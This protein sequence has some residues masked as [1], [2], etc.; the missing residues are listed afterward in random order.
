MKDFQ[1]SGVLM[2]LE[3]DV[4]EEVPSVDVPLAVTKTRR[5]IHDLARHPL[6][7]VELVLLEQDGAADESG[8][9]KGCTLARQLAVLRFGV[10]DGG[11]RGRETP[12]QAQCVGLLLQGVATQCMDGVPRITPIGKGVADHGGCI[13]QFERVLRIP[14]T[15][16]IRP[17]AKQA[18]HSPGLILGLAGDVVPDEARGGGRVAEVLEEPQR[19]LVLFRAS[20]GKLAQHFVVRTTRRVRHPDPALRLA[21]QLLE[22]AQFPQRCPARTAVAEMG[23]FGRA[24]AGRVQRIEAERFLREMAHR[25]GSPVLMPA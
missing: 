8:G 17:R 22:R 10:L 2:P 23:C 16:L 1:G 24:H 6:C 15:H 19:L 12:Q 3:E 7:G 14:K 9:Q 13:R 21:Q 18:S 25:S 11:Q 4:A 5:G 20:D